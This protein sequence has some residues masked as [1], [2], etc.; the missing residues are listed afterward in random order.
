MRHSNGHN[1]SIV[2]GVGR[3]G[4]MRGGKKALWRDEDLAEKFLSE[5][6][7]FIQADSDKPFFL[8]YA[9]HQPHVPRIPNERFAGAS[10]LGPRGDVILEM[11]DC[12]G[13]LTD[14]LEKKGLLENTILLFTSD[15]GPV[16]DDGYA[17]DAQ[18]RNTMMQHRPAGPL[19]GGKYSKFE[20]GAR[21]PFIVSWK[22]HIRPAVS[23]AFISQVDFA[24]SFAA[25]LGVELGDWAPDSQN[26]LPAL[27]GDSIQGRSE[28]FAEAMNKSHFLR[29][30]KW[31]YMEPSE[32]AAHDFTTDIELGNSLDPQ[33]YNMEYDIGQRVNVAEIHPDLVEKMSRRIEEIKTSSRTR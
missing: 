2:N 24:A 30:G 7:N 15:N 11:D 13:K 20:G 3:I 14:F 32:G 22:S 23:P 10:G 9:L 1:N 8:Y 21:I 16:L 12:I 18:R 6:E 25:M 27:L 5:A 26:V 4:F 17:D 28:I 31:T 33:L 29:Q 19:R